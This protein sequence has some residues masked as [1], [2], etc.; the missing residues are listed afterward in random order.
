MTLSGS[1][2]GRIEVGIT[3]PKCVV[4]TL[5]AVPFSG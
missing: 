3:R 4:A 2:S 1:R 5:K